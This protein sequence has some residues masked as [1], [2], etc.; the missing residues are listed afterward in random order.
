MRSSAPSRPA[1]AAVAVALS[2]LARPASS[3]LWSLDLPLTFGG[4]GGGVVE[5]DPVRAYPSAEE[6]VPSFL[7][8]SHG[9]LRIRNIDSSEW[10]P[11]FA[12]YSGGH[13]AGTRGGEHLLPE[14]GLV[15]STGDP[16]GFVL[17]DPADEETG[18]RRRRRRL[19]TEASPPPAETTES[20][21]TGAE[22]STTGE[23][24][25]GAVP[26]AECFLEFEVSCASGESAEADFTFVFGSDL[27][28]E[29]DLGGGGDSQF[30]IYINGKNVA[31]LPDFG[32]DGQRPP[33][34][35]GTVSSSAES[36]LY[37]DNTGG[38]YPDIGAAGITGRIGA[39]GTLPGEGRWTTVRLALESFGGDVDAGASWAAVRGSPIRCRGDGGGAASIGVEEVPIS[40]DTPSDDT[41]SDDTPTDD[42]PTDASP[43]DASPSDASPSDASSSDATPSEARPSSSP[44]ASPT[45]KSEQKRV[46]QFWNP[47]TGERGD[48]I[49]VPEVSKEIAVVISSLFF[50]VAL[51][52][53]LCAAARKGV[54]RR[55]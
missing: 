4:S 45:A 13:S 46:V 48:P 31:A 55:R 34:S 9:D 12:L 10:P 40:D 52:M 41:P 32:G 43:S 26:L 21:T 33:V 22:S 49:P 38:A 2:S 20:T 37:I 54:R 36:G 44:T 27:Y 1:A 19:G 16:Y 18:E 39:S 17:S 5:P 25:G 30:G 47:L 7:G 14:S 51:G 23:E 15:L 11:C 6:A 42:I 53:V 50:V 3:E 29:P 8:G 35:V 24:D 28:S